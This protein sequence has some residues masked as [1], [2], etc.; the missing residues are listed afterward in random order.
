MNTSIA[1]ANIGRIFTFDHI[2]HALIHLSQRAAFFMETLLLQTYD[3]LSLFSCLFSF[4]YLFTDNEWEVPIY[5]QKMRNL[6]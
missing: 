1:F 5:R 2:H 3:H 6:N 4:F